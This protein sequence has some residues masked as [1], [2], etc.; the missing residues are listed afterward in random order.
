MIHSIQLLPD[1]HSAIKGFVST[2]SH[3]RERGSTEDASAANYISI[4]FLVLCG[5]ELHII[6][7]SFTFL[8]AVNI[9]G[10]FLVGVIVADD[11]NNCVERYTGIVMRDNPS[12]ARCLNSLSDGTESKARTGRPIDQ[13]SVNVWLYVSG[14][15]DR[16]APK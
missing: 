6:H 12:S 11:R 5:H 8:P 14:Q 16:T 2:T 7:P 4:K 10:L 15:I 1:G 9:G 13:S 3:R